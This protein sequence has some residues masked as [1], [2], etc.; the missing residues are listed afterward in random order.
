MGRTLCFARVPYNK[1]VNELGRVLAPIRGEARIP[2]F[3]PLSKFG[4]GR[5]YIVDNAWGDKSRCTV[6]C[7]EVWKS[8]VPWLAATFL[9]S[10][11]SLRSHPKV[12]STNSNPSQPFKVL[13]KIGISVHYGHVT[14]PRSLFQCYSLHFSFDFF[15]L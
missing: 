11:G 7:K 9:L 12:D 15:L 6:E 10:F 4:G 14:C 13:A 3:G 5:T 2:A 8:R 1:T